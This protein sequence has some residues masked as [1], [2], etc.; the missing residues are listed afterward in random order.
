MRRC[1]DKTDLGFCGVLW[2]RR[3][4]G[5]GGV[6]GAVFEV[7]ERLFGN[8]PGRTVLGHDLNGLADRTGCDPTAQGSGMDVEEISGLS[9]AVHGAS[10]GDMDKAT[11][12]QAFVQKMPRP[13][14]PALL[15][16]DASGDQV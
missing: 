9:Q 5:T 3:W 15:S 16:P 11:V 14:T 7:R 4:F 1:R 2:Y 10:M 8:A 12:T 6:I 13:W